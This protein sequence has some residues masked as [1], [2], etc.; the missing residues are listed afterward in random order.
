MQWPEILFIFSSE[1]LFSEMLCINETHF[2][3]GEKAK[4]KSLK[5]T[6]GKGE[7]HTHTHKYYHTTLPLRKTKTS[8]QTQTKPTKQIKLTLKPEAERF[9]SKNW[10]QAKW[11]RIC[12]HGSCCELTAE[13]GDLSPSL[14]H[15]GEPVAPWLPS[16]A[17]HGC[18]WAKPLAGPAPAL[19]RVSQE[20]CYYHGFGLPFPG[21]NGD[22]AKWFLLERHSEEGSPPA[23]AESPTSAVL[24][25]P[26][27]ACGKEDGK[28][29][30]PVLQPSRAAARGCNCLKQGDGK[31]LEKIQFPGDF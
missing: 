23:L 19:P 24:C 18:A 17:L 5:L 15:A 7:A 22:F 16:G 12:K 28:E 21:G 11:K 6:G 9:L 3:A 27:W 30:S 29:A 1:A 25:Y 20:S 26:R 2:E 14:A 4:K 8:K 10:F 13:V 31:R